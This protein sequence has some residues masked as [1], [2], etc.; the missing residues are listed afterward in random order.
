MSTQKLAKHLPHYFGLIGLLVAGVVGFVLF[1]YDRVFQ[2][3]V[4]VAMASAYIVWGAFHHSVHKDL[5][6][7]VIVEYVVVSSLGLLIVLSLILRV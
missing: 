2:I 6:L 4:A 7:E 5:Y 3:Y 1:S